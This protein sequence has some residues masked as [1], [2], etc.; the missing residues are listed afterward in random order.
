VTINKAQEKALKS[1]G[2][3][4]IFV[5]C[6]SH[7]QLCAASSRASSF[8]NVVISVAEGPRQLG[9]NWRKITSNIV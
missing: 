1:A 4:L 7:D 2:I 5:A 6:V 9:E 3:Y 8:E